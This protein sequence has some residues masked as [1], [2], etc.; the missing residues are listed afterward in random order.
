MR[1][2]K[3]AKH[4]PR[5]SW[6]YQHHGILE[7]SIWVAVIGLST[8]VTRRTR[9]FAESQLPHLQLPADFAGVFLILVAGPGTRFRVYRAAWPKA[10]LMGVD[11]SADAIRLCTE[12]YGQLAEFVCGGTGSVPR[13]DIVICS[14]VLEHV[15]DDAAVVTLLLKRC[16]KLYVVVPYQENPLSSE[17]VRSYDRGAFRPFHVTRTQVFKARG[18]TEVGLACIARIG[19][20]NLWRRLRGQPMRRRRMQILFEIAGRGERFQ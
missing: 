14:N 9:L 3:A 16:E 4:E 6:Q 13:V 7:S 20:G 12:R 10:K 2:Q 11:F 8:A 17:H 5:H 18:W 19:L 1:L 15:E